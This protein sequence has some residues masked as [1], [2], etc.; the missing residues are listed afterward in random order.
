MNVFIGIFSRIF[1]NTYFPEH[2]LSGFF[3]RGVLRTL[4]RW[5]FFVNIMNSLKPLT[6]FAKKLHV[7]CFT[8]FCLRLC[9]E[10][11]SS[12]YRTYKFKAYC[13]SFWRYCNVFDVVFSRMKETLCPLSDLTLSK[14]LELLCD[15]L[16]ATDTKTIIY[17]T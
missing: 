11:T 1:Q 10:V 12:I 4:P 9:S 8:R 2:L 14:N 6:I 7:R 3:C 13:N 17:I 5:S 15:C 16:F